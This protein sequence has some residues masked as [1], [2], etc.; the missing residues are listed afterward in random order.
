MKQFLLVMAFFSGLCSMAIEMTASRMLQNIFQRHEYHLGMYYR[1][2]IN[3]PLSRK[4]DR[5]KDR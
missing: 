2:Y 5:R 3:L 1:F 4:L